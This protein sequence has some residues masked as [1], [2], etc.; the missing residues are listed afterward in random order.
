VVAEVLTVVADA[1]RIDVLGRV[2]RGDAAAR[3]DVRASGDLLWLTATLEV[4]TMVAIAGLFLAWLHRIVAN[5]PALGGRALRFTPGWAIGWWFVPVASMFRPF[6]VVGEAWRAATGPAGGSTPDTRAMRRVPAFL[7]AWW[8]LFLLG[9]VMSHMGLPRSGGGVQAVRDSLGTDIA[10]S[11]VL[12]AAA[13]LCI[14]LVRRLTGLQDAKHAIAGPGPAPPA[15]RSERLTA[16]AWLTIGALVL[17]AL[18]GVSV[19]L[20]RSAGGASG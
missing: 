11:L 2:L 6:Q 19:D 8:G 10:A 18:V 14:M 9:S 16:L 15:G 7:R 13:V 20:H 17:A 4:V 3:G 12:M 5:G 1:R